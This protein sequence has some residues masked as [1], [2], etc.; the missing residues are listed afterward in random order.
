MALYRPGSDT[1]AGD[2]DPHSLW[3][4]VFSGVAYM[5][6]EEN[7]IFEAMVS[8]PVLTNGLEFL[9][10]YFGAA[11]SETHEAGAM[12]VGSGLQ[13]TQRS[14]YVDKRPLFT[15]VEYDDTDPLF[16]QWEYKAGVATEHGRELA[17]QA[18]KRA[19]RLIV[20]SARTTRPG[21]IA[22]F[23]GGGTDGNGT[24]HTM[25][26]YNAGTNRAR[27]VLVL[28]AIDAYNVRAHEIN[29]PEGET[30]YCVVRPAVWEAMRDINSVIYVQTAGVATGN[31]AQTPMAADYTIPGNPNPGIHSA[32]SRTAFL[33][34]KGVQIYQSN[35]IPNTNVTTNLDTWGGSMLKTQGMIWKA[36]AVG[37]GFIRGVKVETGRDIRTQSDMIVSSIQTGGGGLRVEGAW[38]LIDDT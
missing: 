7:N 32:L 25:T 28:Q 17:R 23:N 9:F 36:S 13:K 34:Y 10:N 11:S 30:T 22:E 2:L 24:A 21:G 29:L 26:G 15:S 14:I 12:I 20:N 19:A 8:K 4:P 18:D 6:F 5:A 37:M 33:L 27:A 16:A 38:E 31:F 1:A 3:L 35:N